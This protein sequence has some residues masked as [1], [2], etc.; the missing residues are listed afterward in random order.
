LIERNRGMLRSSGAVLAIVL[1]IGLRTFVTAADEKPQLLDSTLYVCVYQVADLPVYRIGK[2]LKSPEFDATLLVD[3]I[4]SSVD[5]KSWAEA[6][7]SVHEKTASLVIRQTQANH[8][9][10]SDAIGALREKKAP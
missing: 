6:G 4:R 5:P 1:F 8:D 2:D 9:K 3:F 7:I 10:I